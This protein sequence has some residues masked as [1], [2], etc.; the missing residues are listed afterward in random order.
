MNTIK[1]VATDM[2][3][4]LLDSRKQLPANFMKWVETHPDIKTVI[5]S[6][7]QYYNLEI[8]FAPIKDKLIFI[9][10]NGGL[11]FEKNKA[12]YCNNMRIE[13]V[14]NMLDFLQTIPDVTPIICGVHSAYM[15]HSPA[16]SEENAHM[17]YT[18]LKFLD[19]IKEC[20][21]HD[22]IIKLALFFEKQNAEELFPMIQNGLNDRLS[23]QLSGA[24]WIDIA[25]SSVNKGNAVTAVM[26]Q[27]GIRKSEAMAFGDYLNDYTLLQACGESYAM[28]N[29]HPDIKRISRHIAPSNDENGVMRILENM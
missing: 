3:G 18:K 25:N 15:K 6:G 21:E 22:D 23:A 14:H 16:M 26:K 12:I 29:A 13:D 8:L 5:A 11:V 1:L 27:Y 19:N 7:R 10:D 20:T 28:E 9:A 24:R 4:T 17:Y 2:D